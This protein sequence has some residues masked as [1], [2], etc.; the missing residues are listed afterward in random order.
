MIVKNNDKDKFNT[1]FLTVYKEDEYHFFVRNKENVIQG[2]YKKHFDILTKK[3]ERRYKIK[4]LLKEGNDPEIIINKI[5]FE[6]KQITVE[7]SGKYPNHCSGEW[8]I[9]I[10]QFELP[11]P[12]S[13]INSNM[14]TPGEY[15]SFSF[16]ENCSEEWSSY[17]DS[18]DNDNR[19]YFWI[20][21]SL[22]C[23]EDAYALNFN[24]DKKL[25]NRIISKI[26]DEDWRG[27]SCGGCI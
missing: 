10:E 22:E 27:G 26:S 18:G 3:E 1:R 12:E 20:K 6:I 15:Q 11:I 4:R 2:F 7:W 19:L 14:G 25:I 9:M 13:Y 23:L 8:N 21:Y 24:I 17:Y 5:D 16:D